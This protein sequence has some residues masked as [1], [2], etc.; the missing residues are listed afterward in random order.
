MITTYKLL[1]VRC[2]TCDMH[3]PGKKAMPNAPVIYFPGKKELYHAIKEAGWVVMHNQ[4]NN[5]P[6][7]ICSTCNA[8][9]NYFMNLASG[10]VEA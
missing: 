4:E 8:E 7:I 10:E 1:V 9:A 2:D 5:I 6:H 3:Y